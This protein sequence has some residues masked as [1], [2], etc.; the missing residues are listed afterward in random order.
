MVR[1][2][3]DTVGFLEPKKRST[4]LSYQGTRETIDNFDYEFWN[5]FQE[6]LVKSYRKNSVRC[7]LL[8]AKNISMSS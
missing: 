2:L 1:T 8:Y 5:N 3:P 7:K 6:Y 4:R